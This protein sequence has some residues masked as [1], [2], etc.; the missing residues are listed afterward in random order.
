MLWLTC[1][2]NAPGGLPTRVDNVLNIQSTRV[3]LEALFLEKNFRDVLE[4][5]I[6]PTKCLLSWVLILLRE[7]NLPELPSS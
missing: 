2:V 7:L 5:G 1:A 6:N 3:D 4:D